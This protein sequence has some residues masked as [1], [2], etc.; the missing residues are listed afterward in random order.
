M[1][2]Y[3]RLLRNVYYSLNHDCI[4]LHYICPH[5]KNY[6]ALIK[7]KHSNIIFRTHIIGGYRVTSDIYMHF[8]LFSY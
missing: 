5:N 4:A 8:K 1:I 2:G 6:R 3:M 7:T